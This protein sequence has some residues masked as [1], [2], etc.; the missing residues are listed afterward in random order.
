MLWK[1]RWVVQGRVIAKSDMLGVFFSSRRRHTRYW[2]DWSSDVCSSDRRCLGRL[3][4]RDGSGHG[5]VG[6]GRMSR[7]HSLGNC[8]IGARGKHIYAVG[9]EAREYLHGLFR[10]FACS[11]DDFRESRAKTAVVVDAGMAEVFKWQGCEAIRGG[12]GC[13]RATFDLG[14]KFE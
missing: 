13:E 1:T 5:V 10:R 7:D 2:C 11:K 9:G 14:E 3:S 6:C 12:S 8:L 4:Q